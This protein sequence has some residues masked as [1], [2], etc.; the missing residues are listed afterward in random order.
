MHKV[1]KGLSTVYSYMMQYQE[2]IIEHPLDGQTIPKNGEILIA[3]HHTPLNAEG[4][5]MPNL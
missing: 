1:R 2:V 5:D 4:Y 3:L